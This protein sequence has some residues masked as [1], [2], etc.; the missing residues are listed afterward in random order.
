MIFFYEFLFLISTY[1]V[2]AIPFGLLLTKI[3]LHK[4]VRESGSGNIGATNVARVA[5]KKLGAITLLLDG[6]KGALMVILARFLF[7][8]AS[9]LHLFLVAVAII[10]VV[11]HIYPVYLKFKG[12]KGVATALAVLIALDASVGYMC[13]ILWIMVFLITRVSAIASLAA[14]SSSIISSI[15]YEAPFS[16]I[17]LCVVLSILIAIRHKENIQRLLQGK[18]N[19]M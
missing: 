3:F 13:V 7:Q 19:K 11:G 6:A 8:S 1:L 15:Y 5:G 2:G 10:S 12:G 9:H 14:I 4:D 16:Q 18:E 17:F